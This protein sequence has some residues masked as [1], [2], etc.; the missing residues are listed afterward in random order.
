MKKNNVQGYKGFTNNLPQKKT[1]NL[2]CAIAVYAVFFYS[3]SFQM[4]RADQYSKTARTFHNRQHG[5]LHLPRQYNIMPT[6]RV[7][8]NWLQWLQTG[9]RTDG[10]TSE[11]HS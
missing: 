10:W 11:R 9:R 2:I 7:N 6:A 4:F 3:Y 5:L 8:D 1:A